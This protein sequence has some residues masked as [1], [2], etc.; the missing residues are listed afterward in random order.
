MSG[1]FL[2][3]AVILESPHLGEFPEQTRLQTHSTTYLTHQQI[4][5]MVM[6]INQYHLFAIFGMFSA[7][8]GMQ[9]FLNS[10]TSQRSTPKISNQELYTQHW[11]PDLSLTLS[12]ERPP[13]SKFEHHQGEADTPPALTSLSDNIGSPEKLRKA[14]HELRLAPT[15]QFLDERNG[16]PTNAEVQNPSYHQGSCILASGSSS[17]PDH[18]FKNLKSIEYLKQWEGHSS[19]LYTG[20][21]AE[22]LFGISPKETTNI[23]T[24]SEESVR[25]PKTNNPGE[26][27]YF[28]INHD[29]STFTDNTPGSSFN[30]KN[31][32][33]SSQAQDTLKR[34][35][36]EV[37]H[38]DFL[39]VDVE[40]KNYQ[41]EGP[42][43]KKSRSSNPFSKSYTKDLI[44]EQ[45]KY[46]ESKKGGSIKISVNQNKAMLKN[47][48]SN[49][50]K[51]TPEKILRQDNQNEVASSSNFDPKLEDSLR[52]E[53]M[54]Q[55]L[56]FDM[57]VLLVEHPSPVIKENLQAF[58]ES[59][60][61]GERKMVK[62]NLENAHHDFN[63]ISTIYKISDPPG[64][65]PGI[66]NKRK[67][68][69]TENL[70]RRFI[71][72]WDHQRD[73][74]KFWEIYG[75]QFRADLEETN[76][77]KVTYYMFMK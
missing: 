12:T 15:G 70:V 46:L 50:E 8:E 68:F 42:A 25:N 56:N 44:E 67:N 7:C 34:T 47:R 1:H 54:I 45:K 65:D 4:L 6:I 39:G 35:S 76:Y 24:L 19:R 32:F 62:L 59:K 20:N 71:N 57:G 55:V 11:I 3:F 27:K 69:N 13:M 64:T 9:D 37:N 38:H 16:L 75:I 43:F 49:Q 77:Y 61:S 66:K 36:M 60:T 14:A 30:Y 18:S 58:F 17:S 52:K 28:L 41:F 72:L 29:S 26:T 31:G 40:P 2:H 48:I 73:W 21:F 51:V 33:C 10:F 23:N 53:K 5:K 74:F 63:D 22:G